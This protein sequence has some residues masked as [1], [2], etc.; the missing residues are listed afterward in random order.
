MRQ[1]PT[2]TTPMRRLLAV[3]ALLLCSAPSVVAGD[4]LLR[5]LR[6]FDQWLED[7]Q[8][9]GIDSAY[10]EVPEL[11]HQVYIG[12]Y[13]YWQN[14][15]MSMPFYVENAAEIVPGL[16]DNDRYR[17]NAYTFQD[18]VDL[19]VDW[20]GLTVELPLSIFS[21]Y[22]RSI[23][24]AKTGNVWGFRMR[25]KHLRQMNGD[26]NVGDQAINDQTN[27]LRVFFAE[28]YYVVNSRR[29]SLAAGLYADMVQKRSA[30][31]PLVYI[32]YYQSRYS[33]E[34]LFPAS[35]DSFRTQQISIGAGY[36]Y[37]YSLLRGRL[38]F[39]GSLVPMLSFWNRLRHDAGYDAEQNP[40]QWQQWADFYKVAHTGHA[41]FRLNAFAR[42]A[43]NY[44]WNRHYIISFLANYRHYGY[45]NSRDL[46]ILNR[47][48]DF[49]INACYR[50]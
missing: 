26:C 46:K 41:N 14:Y 27:A 33:V 36:A 29:F 23:G 6:W 47:E 25:Y 17:I 34:K 31:S 4:G 12:N 30:G 50:F 37:N 28:G 21:R 48:A 9:A 38:L 43:V 39:H 3:A 35:F 40:D 49:Q 11:N 19:G 5:L 15:Q 10:V 7:G 42:L 13:G 8:R 2:L 1:S 24:V 45:S 32:N 44:T 16:H 18:E 22:L 20:K